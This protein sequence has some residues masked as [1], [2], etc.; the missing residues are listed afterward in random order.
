VRASAVSRHSLGLAALAV[1]AAAAI[2]L[3]V[4]LATR[5]GARA[6]SR[7][8]Y[9]AHVSSVCRTYARRLS[10]IGAPSDVAAYGD[11]L[12]TV[13]RVVPLLREQAARMEAVDAPP[14]LQADLDGLF[15]LD[16]RSI[17]ALETTLAAARRR[18]AGGV[19]NGIVRFSRLSGQVHSLATSLG[20][21]CT[22]S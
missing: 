13:G 21:R 16:R 18:D 9:L 4:W 1:A 19:G 8:A 15:A 3:G 14:T 12:A 2:A 5:G 10:R 7:S 17:A 22:A 11:V 20:I 6:P